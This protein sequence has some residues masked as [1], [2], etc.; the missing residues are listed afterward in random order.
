MK[1]SLVELAPVRRGFGKPAAVEAAIQSAVDA[2]KLG[3]HRFWYAEHHNTSSFAAQDPVALI[4]RAVAETSTIRLGSGAVLLNHYSPFSVAERFTQL[5]SMA[6]GRIDLGIGRA[7]TGR[8]TDVALQRDRNSQQVDDY[9]QQIQEILAYYHHAFDEQHPFSTI[10]ITKEVPGVP[11]IWI[12]GSS[13]SSAAMAGSLGVGYAFAG[14]INPAGAT[15]SLNSHRENFQVTP[16]GLSEYQSILA[17]NMVAANDEDTAHRL[18]WPARAMYQ[19]LYTGG[20]A[21]VPTVEEAA[22]EL[23]DQA[24]QEPSKIVDGVIPQQVSGTVESIREQLKPIVEATRAT[25]VMVQDMLVDADAKKRS[26]E[27]I[28]EALSGLE[29]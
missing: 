14:F 17:V 8:I 15:E 25:E 4:A 27:I 6:P 22:Q 13:G 1:Y 20:A 29:A 5:Q 10:N 21:Y 19:S 26:R 11:E 7:T 16:Y 3:Y 9:A 18:T 23:T 24:K 2:E 12:L 28:A